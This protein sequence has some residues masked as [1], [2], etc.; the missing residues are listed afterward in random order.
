MQK[1][2]EGM[3]CFVVEWFDKMASLLRKYQL[4][5]YLKDGM[6]EMY[7]PKNRRTFLKKCN[8]ETITLK[9]L[10]IGAKISVYSRQ[11][12]IASY[13]D[14]FTRQ[15][16]EQANGKTCCVLK[17]PAYELFGKIIDCFLQNGF[18]L[19]NAK[20]CSMN[21]QQA[22]KFLGKN[23]MQNEAKSLALDNVLALELVGKSAC[24]KANGFCG[25]SQGSTTDSKL[26]KILGN[27]PVEAALRVSRSTEDVKQELNFF[28]GR[29]SSITTSATFN[30]CTICCVKPGAVQAGYTGAVI[31]LILNEGYEISGLQMFKIDQETAKEF[32]E[33]YETVVPYFS[34][35]AKHMTEG[36]LVAIEVR[37][38]KENTVQMFREFVGPADPVVAKH[39]RP[40]TLRAKFGTDK[41][42]NG[43]HCTDL[44]EDGILE[45]E[46]FFNILQKGN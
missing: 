19:A 20:L 23:A 34:A 26:R 12:T 37:T 5:Y 2:N 7:D 35:M 42:K 44:P 14:E 6:I 46:F 4:F 16:L 41:I 36:P 9:N 29:P 30:N 32:M 38:E 1:N 33:V 31:D 21:V 24:S 28:F 17:A 40:H 25:F 10:H 3:Y 43:I 27:L 11:L 39:V 45:S 13:G 8:Y 18:H 15:A 22:G